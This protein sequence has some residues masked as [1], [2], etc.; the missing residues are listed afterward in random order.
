MKKEFLE[1]GQI[2]NTHGIRGEVKLVPWADGP[3]FVLKF[4]TLYMHDTP[5]RVLS[6]KVHKGSVILALEG[7]EDVNAAMALKGKVLSIRRED[8]KLPKG[9]FFLQDIIGADVVTEQGEVVGT[10]AD[11]L[12]L[13]GN[14]VYVVKGERE[15]LIPAVPEFILN[16][17]ADA[18]KITV[19]LI[20]GL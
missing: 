11:V 17:D 10:L 3:E 14:T 12:D 20:E 9:S 15:I 19:R 5:V 13:P 4:K 2:V 7:V 16:T 6:A 18:G 8:A 1:V